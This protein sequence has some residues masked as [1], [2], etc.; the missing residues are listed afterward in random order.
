MV[1]VLVVFANHL[2]GWP[3]GGF[4]GVDV[5]F[6]I[7][8][9]LI[10]SNLLRTAYRTGS[11]SFKDF[12][13][14]RIRRIVPAA[15]IVLILTYLVSLI[16]FLPFRAH[17]V[18]IDAIFAFIFMANWHFAIL[19]TDYFEGGEAVS[20]IQHYWSLSIEE[21]FY[22]VWPALIFII[23]L[24][25]LKRSWAHHHRMILAGSVMGC[26]VTASFVWAV[27][28]T[29]ATPAWAYFDT[30]ARVWELG[31]GALLA[32][33]VGALGKVSNQLRPYLSW[34]GLSVIGAGV[35]LISEDSVGF[36]APWALLPVAGAALVIAA[37]V[38]E[39]PRLQGLLQN[40]VS[41]YIGD[42]S[43]SLYLV[44]WP[45]IVFLSAVMDQG[46]NFYIA[47]SCLSF[48][49]A[50]ASYH[51]IENP[52][53]RAEWRKLK[54]A[55]SE[56][57]NRQY[58]FQTSSRYAAVAVLVL[59]V[60]ALAAYAEKPRSDV[61]L[62]PQATSLLLPE[63]SPSPNY[64]GVTGPLGVQLQSEIAEALKA[65]EWPQLDP[66]MEALLENAASESAVQGCYG[67]EPLTDPT[68]CSWGQED[69]LT[70]VVIVGDSI[71]GN[72]TIPLREIALNSG[73]QISVYTLALGGCEFSVDLMYTSDPGRLEA[74]PTRKQA[75]VDFIN[76]TKPDVVVISNNYLE[77]RINGTDRDLG[78]N[79]WAESVGALV[80]LFR[81]S[82]GKIV[83]L[84]PP[85]TS[86][87][88]S[89]CYGTRGSKP[90]NCLGKVT[91]Q[92]L[93]MAKAE[94]DLANAIGGVWIDSRPWFC[95][96][97][98]LCPSFVGSTP[99]KLD[100][101][102]MVPAYGIKIHPVIKESLVDAG[103]F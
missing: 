100:R 32:T 97:N 101:T 40:P 17:Q 41:T 43:Y 86:P 5:F 52:L 46:L 20:P 76:Q 25:V 8:G 51:F 29:K 26:L 14:N 1:A 73:D 69:A 36:P 27:A 82:T 7:S 98:G 68:I 90:A 91:K 3:R 35:L 18:G 78:A 80:E 70:R 83:F 84:S 11:I 28:Q 89:E 30:F 87:L 21:Q 64:P 12:Y 31:V 37:G 99:T 16:I 56:I 77:K 67:N 24:I 2:T 58:E 6:V 61:A 13:W 62:P 88:I 34:L 74:C 45:V 55:V 65:T 60:A 102:H 4:V 9:F 95:N 42:I 81:A 54:S 15:T 72:Y 59:T 19:D 94:G 66:P 39:E 57:V 48:A 92:W 53:R 49:L 23:S 96:Q 71:A 10:T 93:E 85:P 50:I 38:G 44:H 75:A 63:D 22:F 47:V 33:C 103:A 79:E